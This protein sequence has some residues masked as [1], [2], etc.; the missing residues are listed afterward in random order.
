MEPAKWQRL[1]RERNL[2]REDLPFNKEAL[3]AWYEL[4]PA[5]YHELQVQVEATL[6]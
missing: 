6:V 5:E 3:Y 2:E 1:D 4:V